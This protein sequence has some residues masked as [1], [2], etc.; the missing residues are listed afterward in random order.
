MGGKLSIEVNF[1]SETPIRH[2][3]FGL[4][5]TTADGD[6]LLNLNNRFQPSPEFDQPVLKGTIRCDLGMVPLVARRYFVSLYMGDQVHDSHVA[7]GAL[8][9]EVAEHDIWGQGKVP[10]PATSHLWWPTNFSFHSQAEEVA[11]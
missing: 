4:V 8:S 11:V 5:I 2:P 10:P 9:F 3:R 1:E 6:K 7:E